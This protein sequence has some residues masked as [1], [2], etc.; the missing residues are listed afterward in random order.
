M[1]DRIAFAISFIFSPFLVQI[2]ASL[3]VVPI[4]AATRNQALL[5]TLIIIVFFS[6]LPSLFILILAHSGHL[7]D[8][9]LAVQEQRLGPLCFSVASGLVGT[10]ILYWIGAPRELVWLGI[11]YAINGGIFTL[12]TPL[13]KISF[14]SGVTAACVTALALLVNVQFAWLFFLSPLIAWARVRR[15]R[16]TIPQTVVATLL[17]IF[18]TAAALQ[19]L[20]C[21]QNAG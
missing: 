3:L 14:H 7:S 21:A 11:V 2:A 13:W 9:H 17:S 6:M 1:L 16:H 19:F 12:I 10:G 18:S 20:S 5:C 15:K 8:L 4:Y